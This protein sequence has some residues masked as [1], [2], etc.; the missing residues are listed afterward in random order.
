MGD[1]GC[2]GADWILEAVKDG[3][4]KLVIRWSPR[5]GPVRTLGL[6][7]VNKLGELKIPNDEIY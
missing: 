5:N 1:R 2:D 6:T 3:R 7:M 4:Y